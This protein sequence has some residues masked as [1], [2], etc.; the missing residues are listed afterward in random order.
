MRYSN[1]PLPGHRAARDDREITLLDLATHSVGLPREIG[2]LPPSTIPFT[3]PTKQERWSFLA[4]HTLPWAPGTVAAYSNVSFDLLAD[5]LAAASGKD[6]PTLLHDRITG[7]LGMADTGVAPT[8][9]TV[10]SSN[11]GQRLRRAWA[12]RRHQCRRRQ[13][14]PLFDRQ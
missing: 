10:Q 9:E 8:P 7:P 12:L 3:W 2:D 6:Y 5:A 1:M 14:R 13:W 4:G 11:D